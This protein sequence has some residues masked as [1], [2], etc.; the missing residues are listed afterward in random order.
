MLVHGSVFHKLDCTKPLHLYLRFLRPQMRAALA[1]RR[2]RATLSSEAHRER[3][4]P[5]LHKKNEPKAVLQK[6]QMFIY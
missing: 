2:K 6:V 4:L 5:V 3:E 1:G